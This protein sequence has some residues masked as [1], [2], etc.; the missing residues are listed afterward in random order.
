[1]L[2]TIQT[3]AHMRHR[4]IYALL[5][6]WLLLAGTANATPPVFNDLDAIRAAAIGA[7]GAGADGEA[8]VDPRLR[9][10]Q[11]TQ[12]LQAVAS[13]A[14][15]VLVRCDDVPGWRLYVPVSVRR[16][17]DVVVLTAPAR[18]GEPLAASQLAVQRR[19][20]GKASG[21]G[22]GDPAAVV[23]RMPRRALA[24]GTAVTEADLAL[25]APLRRGD[26]VVLVAKAGGIEVRM[27]GR[28]LGPA[29]SSGVVS[30]ENLGSHRILRGR[31]IAEGVV[32]VAL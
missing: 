19:D 25:G 15:T 13:G 6:A 7:L 16:E 11:C 2:G 9:V 30:V 23:G 10:A 14:R 32:E 26:P 12:P 21:A 1:M 31:V 5:L 28:A 3:E 24:R 27:A 18:S 20:M 4:S 29:Q 17:A 8:T 22:F